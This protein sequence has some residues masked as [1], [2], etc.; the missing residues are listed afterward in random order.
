MGALK[1]A[2][3]VISA[4]IWYKIFPAGFSWASGT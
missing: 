1:W 3:I 2:E 4:R